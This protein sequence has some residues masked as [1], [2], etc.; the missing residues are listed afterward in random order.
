MPAALPAHGSVVLRRLARADE[1]AL[2]ALLDTDVWNN[3]YLFGILHCFGLDG[4][5]SRFTG[6]FVGGR[7]VGALGEGRETHCW[8]ASLSVGYADV[9]AALAGELVA[10]CVEV[11][12]GREDVVSAAVAALPATRV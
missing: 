1:A 9:V 12:L 10:P 6:A 2:R 4:P 11:L 8:Y 7:L 3:A 5:R